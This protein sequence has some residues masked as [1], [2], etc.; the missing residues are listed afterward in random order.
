M[1]IDYLAVEQSKN[2]TGITDAKNDKLEELSDSVIDVAG[3][4]HS[5]A[6]GKGDKALLA[7]VNYKSHKVGNMSQAELINAAG[8]VL[9]EVGKI[10]AGLLT[11]EGISAEEVIQF[12]EV[13]NEFK[14]SVGGKREAVIERSVHTYRIAEL[15]TEAADLKKNTLDRLATQFIRKAPEFYNKYKAA[16][17]VI[18]KHSTKATTTDSTQG[19]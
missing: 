5:Y 12:T 17:T 9:E 13:Y 6:T 4:L 3:A 10:P 14:G 15:F 7:K 19:K 11:E 2:L 1:E 16:S 18:H 8:V